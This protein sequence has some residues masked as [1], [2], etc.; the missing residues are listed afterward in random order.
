MNINVTVNIHLNDARAW[1]A[2]T[3]MWNIAILSITTWTWIFAPRATHEPKENSC[4]SP[5][6]STSRSQRP[7]ANSFKFSGDVRV[8]STLFFFFF[9]HMFSMPPASF[10][11]AGGFRGRWWLR[12]ESRR[13]GVCRP[14]RPCVSTSTTLGRGM[15]ARACGS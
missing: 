1:Y 14:R 10:L 12:G 5:T 9:I 11:H 6:L 7:A 8:S 15:R 2:S 3:S 13:L 4:S